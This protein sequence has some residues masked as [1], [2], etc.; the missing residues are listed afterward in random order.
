MSYRYKINSQWEDSPY[1]LS[2]VLIVPRYSIGKHFRYTINYFGHFSYCSYYSY[3]GFLSLAQR[4]VYIF[5]KVYIMN[6]IIIR[7]RNILLHFSC[8]YI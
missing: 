8:L 6:H 5:K 7:I 1:V 3:R 2:N 4:F